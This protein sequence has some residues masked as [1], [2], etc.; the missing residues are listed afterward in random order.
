MISELKPDEIDSV[1]GGRRGGQSLDSLSTDMAAG[2]LIGASVGFLVGGPVG[3]AAFGYLGGS[4]AGIV[5]S[6]YHQKR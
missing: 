4:M 3:A 2:A 1:N 5:S 6:I